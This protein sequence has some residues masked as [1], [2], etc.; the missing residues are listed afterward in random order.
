MGGTTVAASAH[1]EIRGDSLHPT[2]LWLS[3]GNYTPISQL[4]VKVFGCPGRPDT[5]HDPISAH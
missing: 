5:D 3:P 2:P 4:S 1:V